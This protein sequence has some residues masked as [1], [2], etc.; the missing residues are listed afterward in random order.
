M[1]WALQRLDRCHIPP[2][3]SAHAVPAIKMQN[4]SLILG[5][6]PYVGFYLWYKFL[7]RYNINLDMFFGDKVL[8]KVIIISH[9][10][11]HSNSQLI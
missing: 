8:F 5:N 11:I 2:S 9:N 3:G 6:I 7:T 1:T 4:V 10:S